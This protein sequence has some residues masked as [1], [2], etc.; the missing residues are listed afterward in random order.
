M[1]MGGVDKHDMLRQLYGSDSKSKRW[2]H[3][4]FFGLLDMV[5]VNSYILY[6]DTKE[7]NHLKLFDYC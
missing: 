7:E 2:W 3:R 5:V 6:S 1:H 4:L